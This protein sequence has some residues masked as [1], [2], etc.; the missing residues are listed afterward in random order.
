MNV[1]KTA[2]TTIY[3]VL[4]HMSGLKFPEAFHRELESRIFKPLKMASTLKGY[5]N[6]NQVALRARIVTPYRFD[7]SK[8]EFSVNREALN[9]QAAF[10]ATGLLSTIM[11]LATYT[12]AL[13]DDRLLPKGAYERMTTPF[14]SN[15][16]KSIAYGFGWFTEQFAGTALHWAYGN[17][18]SDAA[19]L[20]RVPVRKMTLI[21]LCNA[22]LPSACSRLGGGNALHSPFV[23]AFIKHFILSPELTQPPIGYSGSIERVR[24][25]LKERQKTKPHPI[26]AEE[27]FSQALLRTYAEKNTGAKKGEAERLTQLLCEFNRE[28][29]TNNDPAFFYLLSQHVGTNLDEAAAVAIDAYQ[30]TGRFHPW[31]LR[32]IAQRYEAKGDLRST[33]AYSHKLVDTPGFEEQN[34][35]QDACMFLAQYYTHRADFKRGRHYAWLALIWMRQAG[36]SDSPARKIIDEINRRSFLKVRKQ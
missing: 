10:P 18:D 19:M 14:V 20:L 24:N 34:D 5:P 23:A 32:S 26:H 28:A 27:L 13:D 31:I 1:R 17:G 21:V 22:N 3:G 8:R 29:L 9:M 36:Y 33:V 12:T 25:E 11:D 2:F 7:E 16:G 6:T 30:A 35:K 15:E 4:E